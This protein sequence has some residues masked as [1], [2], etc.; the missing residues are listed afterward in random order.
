MQMMVCNVVLDEQ[1]MD[2]LMNIR[3]VYPS[4]RCLFVS[5][6]VYYSLS[7]VITHTHVLYCHY[8]VFILTSPSIDPD[9]PPS[10]PQPP[11]PRPIFPDVLT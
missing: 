3:S 11:K 5:L 10:F 9:F 2:V 1:N 4:I 8:T 7:A 6:S